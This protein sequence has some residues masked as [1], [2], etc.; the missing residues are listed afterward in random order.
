VTAARIVFRT[1]ASSLIGSGH[2]M[3]CL[4]LAHRLRELGQVTFVCRA[5]AGNLC[6]Q[7][8]SQ[9]F[10]V[11]RLPAD[12][13]IRTEISGSGH[14]HWLGASW[15]SDAAISREAIRARG[16]GASLLIVDHYALDER[17][18]RA[19]RDVARHVMVI[20]DLADRRHDCEVLLDQSLHP[21]PASRYAG[22]VPESARL[23]LG[24]R[25]ALLRPEFD[26]VMP[27]LR[28]SGLGKLFIFISGID[29]T[30]EALKVLEALRKLG[31][32]APSATLVLGPLNADA[33]AIRKA[34]ERIDAVT[35]LD[36]TQQMAKLMSDADLGVGT[37]GGAAWE[38]C[39]VGLPTIVVI[40]AENQRN[41]TQMLACTGA[42]RNLGDAAT[43]SVDD[44]VHAI[45]EL[46]ADRA[47]L[48]EM[49]RAAL[50]VMEGRQAAARE[51]QLAITQLVA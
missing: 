3:R 13:S 36:V 29:P 20:D 7:I 43:V 31:T 41:D 45:D 1:D 22:L 46:R 8:A 51:L 27:R 5:H 38:R 47:G 49:S 28:Q 26:A 42:V 4:T 35:I 11:E 15:Q 24:P 18:E 17:W 14:A 6:D 33:P 10:V 19:L 9:G 32:G 16:A 21:A 39:A 40:N 25:Y 34:A 48:E 50:A 37:C 30:H 44:W 23:F 2:V 12:G